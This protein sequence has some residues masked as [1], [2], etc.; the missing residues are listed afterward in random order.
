MK[1]PALGAL[2]HRVTIE[3]PALLT[4]AGGGASETW[5]PIAEVF[6]EIVPAS[7]REVVTADRISAEA[8]HRITLRFR[9]DVGPTARIRFGTR[10]FD[11]LSV[12]NLNERNRWLVCD[13]KEETA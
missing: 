4:D 6:A 12:R 2:R 13:C 9:A 10:A 11:I 7:G 1:A 8:S 3:A 5:M